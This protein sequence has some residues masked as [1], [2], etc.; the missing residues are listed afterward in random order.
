MVTLKFNVTAAKES[1]FVRYFSLRN[2]KRYN[3]QSCGV[4][5]VLVSTIFVCPEFLSYITGLDVLHNILVSDGT[6]GCAGVQED[7]VW[8]NNISCWCLFFVWVMV[9]PTCSN[10]VPLRVLAVD[11]GKFTV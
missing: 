6:D 2:F 1:M 11:D 7:P 8:I 5:L 10:C 3:F 4:V 9:T